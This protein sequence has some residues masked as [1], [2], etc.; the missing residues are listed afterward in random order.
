GVGGG[1]GWGVVMRGA[2]PGEGR[3]PTHGWLVRGSGDGR[4]TCAGR[5]A[6]PVGPSGPRSWERPAGWPQRRPTAERLQ[7]S[8]QAEET[9]CASGPHSMLWVPGARHRPRPRLLQN[10]DLASCAV[11]GDD[12]VSPPRYLSAGIDLGRL[13]GADPN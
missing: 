4:P 3:R 10:L 11:S 6:S 9:G 12:V 13:R 2:P 5:A 7:C 8:A 1:E